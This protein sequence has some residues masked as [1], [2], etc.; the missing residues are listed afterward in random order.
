MTVATFTSRRHGLQNPLYTQ[1]LWIQYL[2]GNRR[3]RGKGFKWPYPSTLFV[4]ERLSSR[5]SLSARTTTFFTVLGDIRPRTTQPR[6]L[7]C[8][9][10]RG[11]HLI[12]IEQYRKSRKTWR[13]F[14]IHDLAGRFRSGRLGARGNEGRC[15]TVCSA[16]EGC[17]VLANTVGFRKDTTTPWIRHGPRKLERSRNPYRWRPMRTMSLQRGA[18]SEKLRGA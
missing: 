16:P 3:L 6:R 15:S 4:W 12:N 13:S 8:L 17:R 1:V 5:Q 18:G 9:S 14:E 2:V 10:A 11:V 7:K